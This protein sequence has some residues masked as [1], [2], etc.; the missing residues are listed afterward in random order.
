M[1]QHPCRHRKPKGHE[2]SK[3]GDFCCSKLDDAT[4]IL[5][6]TF[7]IAFGKAR[8]QV[9]N[10]LVEG[11]TFKSWLRINVDHNLESSSKHSWQS[12]FGGFAKR[13]NRDERGRCT[14]EDTN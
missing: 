4:A 6:V 12:C 11:Y 9:D 3:L 1:R 7:P 2:S 5:G 8:Q 13:L 10:Y 14:G